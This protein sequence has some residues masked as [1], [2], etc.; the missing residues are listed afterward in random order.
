MKKHEPCSCLVRDL[1]DCSYNYTLNCLEVQYLFAS[2]TDY[3]FSSFSFLKLVSF[4]VFFLNGGLPVQIYC[5][6]NKLKSR[7][8]G[9]TKIAK[10]VYTAFFML[11]TLFGSYLSSFMS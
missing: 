1:A 4:P 11:L 8:Y 6:K 7:V 3:F 5:T 2:K 9:A 10:N